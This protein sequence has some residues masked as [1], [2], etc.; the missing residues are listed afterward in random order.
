MFNRPH[1]AAAARIDHA[2]FDQDGQADGRPFSQVSSWWFFAT[3]GACWSIGFAA[4]AVLAG[5]LMTAPATADV[6]ETGDGAVAYSAAFAPASGLRVMHEGSE[7]RGP[8]AFYELC[9]RSPEL[10]PSASGAGDVEPVRL[11]VGGRAQLEAFNRSVNAAHRPAHDHEVYGDSDFWTLPNGY[12]DCEDYVLAKREALI[13]AGWPPETLLI[14]VV[15]GR[16]SPYHAVLIV[17]TDEGELVLDN[18]TDAVLD[19]RETG[20]EWVVRQSMRDPMLWVRVDRSNIW[21]GEVADAE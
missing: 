19:W 7:V 4:S 11:P 8:R 16:M 2:R 5:M 17:R 10:C 12:A 9:E 21:V 20:Y 14:G 6:T 15:R 1:S 3:A 13:A 18:L